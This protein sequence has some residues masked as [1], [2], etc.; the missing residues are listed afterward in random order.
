MFCKTVTIE[1][2]G[3]DTYISVDGIAPYIKKT[4]T[5]NIPPYDEAKKKWRRMTAFMQFSRGV[6]QDGE[7]N[8][9]C[10]THN[11]LQ[12]RVYGLKVI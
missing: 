10:P 7:D 12:N 5:V 1:Y 2:N 11:E 9:Y 6:C 4:G 8:D 3:S